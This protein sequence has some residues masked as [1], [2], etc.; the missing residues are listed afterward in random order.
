MTIKSSSPQTRMQM[1]HDSRQ[2]KNLKIKQPM[3]QANGKH[4]S[5]MVKIGKYSLSDMEM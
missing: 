3:S 4:S 2:M 1:N 5:G